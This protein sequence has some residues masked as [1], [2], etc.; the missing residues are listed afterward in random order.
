MS[1]RLSRNSC[2]DEP[3]KNKKMR[4]KA[5]AESA[6]TEQTA[7]RSG[8]MEKR[9]KSDTYEFTQARASEIYRQIKTKSPQKKAGVASTPNSA[10]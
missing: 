6:T 4:Y 8:S 1:S 9:Q 7:Q 5:P 3:A 10:G 2:E